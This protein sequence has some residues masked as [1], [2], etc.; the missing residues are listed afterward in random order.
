M[1]TEDELDDKLV[2]MRDQLAMFEDKAKK[3]EEKK[4]MTKM[5]NEIFDSTADNDLFGQSLLMDFNDVEV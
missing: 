3:E 4:I 5:D 2:M 1:W